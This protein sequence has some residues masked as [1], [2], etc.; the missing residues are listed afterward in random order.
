LEKDLY[1]LLKPVHHYDFVF[2][3]GPLD[4]IYQSF[5]VQPLVGNGFVQ[6]R[7]VAVCRGAE[8]VD[9]EALGNVITR[10]HEVSEAE[11]SF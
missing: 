8:D 2:S 4:Y 9:Q 3:D 1:F 6:P 5:F 11:M 10:Y 7:V